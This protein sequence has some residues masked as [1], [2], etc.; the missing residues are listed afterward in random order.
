MYESTDGVWRWRLIDEDGNVMADSGQGEYSS[1][2]DAMSAMMTLQ[3]NAPNAEHLEIENAAF[4]LFQDDRGWGWRLV[5]DIGDTI[6]DG[7]T[8]HESEEGAR[9]AMDSLVTSVS[10]VRE[11]RMEHGV[12]QVYADDEDEWWWRFVRADGDILAESDGSFGTRHEIE[13]A[14]DDLAEYATEAGVATIGRL[15]VLLDP[16]DWRFTLIDRNRD[17]IATSHVGYANRETATDAID[18][19][20]RS[21]PDTDVYEIRGETFDCY[22]TDDGWTWRLVDEDHESIARGATTHD[23]ADGVES[24]V[25]SVTALT[26]G[27]TVVDYD[28]MAFELYG[29]DDGWWWRM[30]DEDQQVLGTA[31]RPYENREDARDDLEDARSEFDR[32]S[33]LEIE[34]AAFEFHRTDDG[35]RWRLVDENGDELAESLAT[36]SSR[37]EA[38]EDLSTVKDLGPEAWVSTAE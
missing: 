32:A 29:D 13:D 11:R 3:E 30:I 1:K 4:E 37:V 38:Q 27:A 6:A 31:A 21:A 2:D 17:P 9:Q 7:A 34:S 15:A 16:D 18:H 10:D 5:D 24:A 22:W 23:E 35:W 33:V 28:D 25:A 8:R 36:F 20:K 12:F 26:P 14:I 19:L